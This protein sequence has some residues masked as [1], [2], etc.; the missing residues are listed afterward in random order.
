M[1]QEM[2]FGMVYAIGYM[3][4]I[5]GSVILIALFIRLLFSAVHKTVQ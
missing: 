5:V 4:G 1:T 3:W 2:L